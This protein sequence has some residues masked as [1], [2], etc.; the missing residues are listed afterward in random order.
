MDV[1]ELLS[2]DLV[3]SI[4]SP[5]D[6]HQLERK[7]SSLCA[8]HVNNYKKGILF[9]CLSIDRYIYLGFFVGWN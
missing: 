4:Y 1:L 8:F 9:I 7:S 2:M 3:P 6:P 5:T